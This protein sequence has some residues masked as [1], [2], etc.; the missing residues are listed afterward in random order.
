MKKRVTFHAKI[1]FKQRMLRFLRFAS[2]V[3]GRRRSDILHDAKH[4]QTLN[5]PN[6]Q[7]QMCVQP[8][9]I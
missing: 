9:L 3:I 6:T 7:P 2:V 5:K 8:S 1:K 4:A